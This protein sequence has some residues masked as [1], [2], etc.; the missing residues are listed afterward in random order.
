MLIYAVIFALSVI[1]VGIVVIYI[2]KPSPVIEMYVYSNNSIPDIVKPPVEQL[3]PIQI[4]Y[5]S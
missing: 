2:K 5:G 4:Y 1:L 3:I